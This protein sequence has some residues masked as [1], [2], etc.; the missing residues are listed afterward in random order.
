MDEKVGQLVE[1]MAAAQV[2][3]DQVAFRVEALE[4]SAGTAPLETRAAQPAELE[5]PA[6]RG[7]SQDA[8]TPDLREW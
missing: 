5:D 3:L 2:A 4:E 8:N 7:P 1:L 6:R